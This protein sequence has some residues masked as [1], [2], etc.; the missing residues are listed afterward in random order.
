MANN[1]ENVSAGKPKIGGAVYRAPAGTTLP[2]DAT[3]DLPSAFEALGYVSEDGVSNANSRD[4]DNIKAWGGD[5]VLVVQTSKN[6]EFKFKLVEALNAAVL[7]AVHGS[8]NVSGNLTDGMTVLANA[9]EVE[10]AVWVIDMLLKRSI[11]KRIVIPC[12]KVTEVE[13]VVYSDSEPIGYGVTLSCLPDLSGN[14][15]YEYIQSTPTGS[16]TLDKSTVSVVAGSTSTITA[17]TVPA[18]GTVKWFSSDTDVAT[19]TGGVVTG[20]AAGTA[21][22]TARVEG[23]GAYATAAVT[24]TAQQ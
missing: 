16:V 6:D 21:T 4:I 14:S 8:T 24:V 10:E 23:T 9:I 17:T 2:T 13:D 7:K 5:T 19:V 20:I 18:G 15:H 12:G 11:C 3:S 22:I 1:V